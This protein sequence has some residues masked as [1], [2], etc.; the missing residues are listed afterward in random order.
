M[1]VWLVVFVPA[2]LMINGGFAA[3]IAFLDAMGRGNAYITRP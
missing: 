3:H 2:S 1:L